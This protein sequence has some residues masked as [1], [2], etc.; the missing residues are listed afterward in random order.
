MRWMWCAL[1][2]MLLVSCSS[3]SAQLT[4]PVDAAER[5]ASEL[6]SQLDRNGIAGELA[7]AQ[8][9]VQPWY[10]WDASSDRTS[11]KTLAGDEMNVSMSFYEG[12]LWTM[13]R[14]APSGDG[15]CLQVASVQD[16]PIAWWVKPSESPKGDIADQAACDVVA[17][18]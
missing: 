5:L 11:L 8:S 15:Y 14:A 3:D 7:S 1:V 9:A 6:G 16:E 4:D 17:P 12:T 13:V 18:N 2:P 10:A